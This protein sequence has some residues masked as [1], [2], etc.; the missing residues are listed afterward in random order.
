VV[1]VQTGIVQVVYVTALQKHA[2]G[3]PLQTQLGST[4]QNCPAGHV[5]KHAPPTPQVCTLELLLVLV[6][7]VVV[8]GREATRSATN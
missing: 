6:L 8:A 3:G 5:P 1:V 2:G 4:T 7:V